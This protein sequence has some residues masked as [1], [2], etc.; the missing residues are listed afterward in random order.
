LSE[1]E[2]EVLE[3]IKKLLQKYGFEEVNIPG[4]YS[5]FNY[6]MRYEDLGSN[7]NIITLPETDC[8]LKTMEILKPR[9]EKIWKEQERNFSK[10]QKFIKEKFYQ[11]EWQIEDDFKKLFKDADLKE[12]IE[13]I[14]LLSADERGGGGGANNGPNTITLECSSIKE[15]YINEK[16]CILWHELTHIILKEYIRDVSSLL[17]KNL[18]IKKASKNADKIKYNYVKELVVYSVFI[19]VSYL[20]GKH[21]PNELYERLV[22]A[23]K[24]DD[25]ESLE[26]VHYTFPAYL[27]YLNGEF[28]RDKLEKKEAISQQEMADAI[29]KNH[30]L[31]EK[32][33]KDHGK[34]VVWFNY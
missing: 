34:K 22:K 20:A 16:L 21:F 3:D 28:I 25:F 5:V 31:T 7:K 4:V 32:Y 9:F 27:I 1:K 12:E 24:D 17:E 26:K 8:F 14:L 13:I 2:K 19:R 18:I 33:F 6:L 29:V 30:P 15:D 10:V 23:V 11:T